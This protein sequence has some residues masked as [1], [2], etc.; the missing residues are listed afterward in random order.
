LT[1]YGYL[2]ASGMHFNI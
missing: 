2:T 1:Y